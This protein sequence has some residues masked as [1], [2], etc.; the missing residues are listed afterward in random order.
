M[1]IVKELKEGLLKEIILKLRQGISCLIQK[2]NQISKIN[3][4]ENKFNNSTNDL[5]PFKQ[6]RFSLYKSKKYDLKKFII[7]K[8]YA[9]LEENKKENKDKINKEKQKEKMKIKIFQFSSI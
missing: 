6:K 8:N 7:P 4:N 1:E 3:L 5:N 9:K 2:R